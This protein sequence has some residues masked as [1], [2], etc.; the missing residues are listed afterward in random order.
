MAGA[1]QRKHAV[2]GCDNWFHS[3]DQLREAAAGLNHVELRGG[4]QGLVQLVRACTERVGQRQQNAMDFLCFFV[5][6]GNDVVV[7]LDG[8][9]RFEEQARA[10]GRRAVHDAGDGGPVLGLDHQHVAPVAVGDHLLLQVLRRVSSA[11]ERLQGAAQPRT[12]TA[13]PP[14]DAGKLRRGVVHHLAGRCELSPDVGDLAD[15]RCGSARDGTEQWEARAE[16][17]DDRAGMF[18]RLEVLGQSQQAKRLQRAPVHF[19]R[20]HYRRQ[21]G[22]GAKREAGMIRQKPDGFARRPEGS[23][24]LGRVGRRV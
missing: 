8:G 22:G 14:A 21:V 5:L 20:V 6:E 18:D 19:E 4:V 9:K 1:A 3:T 12:L 11:E 24:H 16:L 13:Q 15:E 17:C 2:V 10:G 23:G 7:D